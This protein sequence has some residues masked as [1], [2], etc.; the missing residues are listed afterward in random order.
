MHDEPGT[1]PHPLYLDRL[2]AHLK[3]LVD[4]GNTGGVVE[5][6]MRLVAASDWVIDMGSGRATKTTASPRAGRRRKLRELPKGGLRDV[7]RPTWSARRVMRC[8]Q[9]PF[10]P[11]L[12]GDSSFDAELVDADLACRP[13]CTICGRVRWTVG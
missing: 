8:C 10:R 5:P 13:R 2:M 4:A 9:A 6:E 11:A 1:G 3:G 12:A 7:W